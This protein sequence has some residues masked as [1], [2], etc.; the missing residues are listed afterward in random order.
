ME[1]EDLGALLARAMRRIMEAERPLLE[2]HGMS[3]WAYVALTLLARGSAPTQLALAEAMGYDKT[4][5]I[6]ILDGLEGDGLI[7]RA[8]DPS[9]RR[10]K[11]IE[12][13]PAGRAK[14]A[15]IQK[16]VHAME[17]ELL[18]A[19]GATERKALRTA[20]PRLADT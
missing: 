1:R 18:S 8:P 17:D 15:A 14:F 7:T 16:D 10:A 12:L 5:L 6:K 20:L 9:D 11:V 13:T 2:A 19:L 4:R 3:M